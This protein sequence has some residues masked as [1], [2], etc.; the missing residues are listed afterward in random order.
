[1]L[2]VHYLERE[3]TLTLHPKLHLFQTTLNCFSGTK[4]GSSSMLLIKEAPLLPHPSSPTTS[5]MKKKEKLHLVGKRAPTPH[6]QPSH[7]HPLSLSLSSHTPALCSDRLSERK[8]TKQSTI[9]GGT[10]KRTEN[11]ISCSLE[12]LSGWKGW[13]VRYSRNDWT[14]AEKAYLQRNTPSCDSE[15]K[16]YENDQTESSAPFLISTHGYSEWK[17][18]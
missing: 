12:R 7:M 4:F 13:C 3:D 15:L 1:M 14:V 11:R 5:E 2:R 17:A 9:D 8:S 6:T 16:R 18:Q 10:R